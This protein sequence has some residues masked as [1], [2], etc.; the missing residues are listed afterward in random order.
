MRRIFISEL[1]NTLHQGKLR[2]TLSALAFFARVL[3]STRR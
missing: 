1:K 2:L 3:P